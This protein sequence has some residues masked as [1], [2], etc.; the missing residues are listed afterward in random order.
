[1]VNGKPVPTRNVKQV[2]YSINLGIKTDLSMYLPIICVNAISGNPLGVSYFSTFFIHRNVQK[3][4][5]LYTSSYGDNN[6]LEPF[7]IFAFTL[8]FYLFCAYFHV[9]TLIVEIFFNTY[10]PL[11]VI[12]PIMPL[13]QYLLNHYCITFFNDF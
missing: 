13:F 10:P 3:I 4:C 8:T 2:I 6:S 1:M 11:N 9:D 12:C 7:S 5:H